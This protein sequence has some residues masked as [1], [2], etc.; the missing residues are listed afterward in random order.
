MP[1]FLAYSFLWSAPVLR[2][3]EAAGHGC[4]HALSGTSDC[5]VRLFLRDVA[6]AVCAASV[7]SR[8]SAACPLFLDAFCPGCYLA[9]LQAVF[10][11]RQSA[12]PVACRAYRC[13][14]AGLHACAFGHSLGRRGRAGATSESGYPCRRGLG[15][16]LT[17][18]QLHAMLWLWHIRSGLIPWRVLLTSYFQSNLR[19]RCCWCP[20]RY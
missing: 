3:L 1:P 14:A 13:R 18:Y 2:P 7:E 8:L 6:P 17:A 15:A 12:Q 10:L 9:G 4:G 20:L 16:L 19:L 5:G 11:R